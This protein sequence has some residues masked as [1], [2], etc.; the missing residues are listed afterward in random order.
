M[1][2]REP[3]AAKNRSPTHKTTPKEESRIWSA[4]LLRLAEGALCQAVLAFAA[5]SGCG[6]VLLQDV[7]QRMFVAKGQRDPRRDYAG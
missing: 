6:V 5:R 3:Q 7:D 2:A 4:P 1:L